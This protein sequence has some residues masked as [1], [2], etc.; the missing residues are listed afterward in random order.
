MNQ[1]TVLDYQPEQY[2]PLP[3][4]HEKVIASTSYRGKVEFVFLFFACMNWLYLLS[5][6]LRL[7]AWSWIGILLMGTFYILCMLQN[8]ISLTE[9][10]CFYIHVTCSTMVT[11]I[12]ILINIYDVHFYPGNYFPWSVFPTSIA[13]FVLAFHSLYVFATDPKWTLW[14]IH[15]ILFMASY[16]IFIVL[17]GVCSVRKCYLLDGSGV[18][19]VLL[20]TVIWTVFL[21]AHAYLLRR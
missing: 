11:I 21:G 5:I 16:V 9:K 8:K 15:A 6:S 17:A 4:Y 2:L 12:L 14:F 18:I 13:G 3:V 20:Y 1:D 7:N 10:L 19:E